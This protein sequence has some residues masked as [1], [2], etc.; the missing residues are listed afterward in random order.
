MT[1]KITHIQGHSEETTLLAQPDASGSKNAIQAMGSTIT[2][3][4]RYTLLA[5]TGLATHEDD[6]GKASEVE[7]ISEAEGNKILD[8]I[9][10]M[11][12]DLS[13]FLAYMKI[14]SLEKMPKSD[15]KKAISAIE[16][17]MKIKKAGKK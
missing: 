9:T 8:M 17:T 13:K 6:D 16:Q 1:C 11:K 12:G 7:Y 5:L 2:Y 15:Y 14:D 3:L 10:G 4:E